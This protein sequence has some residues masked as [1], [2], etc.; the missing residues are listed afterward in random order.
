MLY[1]IFLEI[2]GRPA[3]VIGGGKVAARKTAGLV[4]AGANVT[5]I[6]PELIP[7]LGTMFE[8]GKIQ[9]RKKPFSSNDLDDAL[10]VI[11]ATNDRETNLKVKEAAGPN[12]L[13]TI[14]DNPAAS[15][16]HVPSVVRR[17]KLNLAVSTSGASPTLAKKVRGELEKKYDERYVDYLEFLDESRTKILAKVID[18][19]RKQQL[20][21]I[22]AEEEYLLDKERRLEMAELLNKEA[23]S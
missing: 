8:N 20:L 11:A 5:V 23:E 1:P 10:L 22:I 6:S 4:E 9:W 14:A 13:V 18:S 21:K 3:V 7:E 15:D 19:E 17:G 12:Q 16:F 2:K